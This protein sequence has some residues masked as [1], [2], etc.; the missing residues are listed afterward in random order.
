[1]FFPNV[2]YIC[3][4]L[5]NSIKMCQLNIN[6]LCVIAYSPAVKPRFFTEPCFGVPTK[7]FAV[8]ISFKGADQESG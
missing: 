6:Q 4:P 7:F 3:R 8:L 2:Y 5:G 1:M